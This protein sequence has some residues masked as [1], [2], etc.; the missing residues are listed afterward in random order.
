MFIQTVE[1]AFIN[2]LSVNFTIIRISSTN[3]STQF[4][5]FHSFHIWNWQKERLC[6]EAGLAGGAFKTHLT[7]VWFTFAIRSFSF[8]PLDTVNTDQE[9]T[10]HATPSKTMDISY[11][12]IS[13]IKVCLGLGTDSRWLVEDSLLT[14]PKGPLY[15]GIRWTGPLPGIGWDRSKNNVVIWWRKQ[16]YCWLFDGKGTNRM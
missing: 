7:F 5:F 12:I 14:S 15:V 8:A 4:H 2:C 16:D 3:Y 10:L 1:P 6:K 11:C 9:Q 13:M